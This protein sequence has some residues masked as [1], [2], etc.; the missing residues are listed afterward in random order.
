MGNSRLSELSCEDQLP[1]SSGF[2]R[3]VDGFF[4]EHSGHMRDGLSKD[5]A[6]SCSFFASSAAEL[7]WSIGPVSVCDNAFDGKALADSGYRSVRAICP[8]TCSCSSTGASE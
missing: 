3:F 4:E 7:Q 1:T 5:S 8:Q 2:K 6:S